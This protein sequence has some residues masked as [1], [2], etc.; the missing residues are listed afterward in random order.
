MTDWRWV[1]AHQTNVTANN[2]GYTVVE[3]T[4]VE[5]G[6]AFAALAAFGEG[7]DL[8]EWEARALAALG[9]GDF[10]VALMISDA[11]QRERDG[12]YNSPLPLFQVWSGWSAGDKVSPKR[13]D[14]CLR[15]SH[16]E[17]V[18]E[19]DGRWTVRYRSE[20]RHF[21]GREVDIM[22]SHYRGS[23][24][25]AAMSSF[26]RPEDDR[27]YRRMAELAESQ[28]ADHPIHHF[29]AQAWTSAVRAWALNMWWRAGVEARFYTAPGGPVGE[30]VIETGEDWGDPVYPYGEDDIP[31]LE[32]PEA[33]WVNAAHPLKK[34]AGGLHRNS[35]GLVRWEPDPRD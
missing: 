23:V 1:S 29:V 8:P 26:H 11:A 32:M 9:G 13:A 12:E 10:D 21:E 27:V 33:R 34:G 24:G 35:R 4:D 25:W 28:P 2:Y 15:G 16:M 19:S 3:R 5:A 7:V 31:F 30:V 17:I 14:V 20:L 6:V 18:E 22:A